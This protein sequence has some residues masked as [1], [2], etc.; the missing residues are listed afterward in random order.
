M[1]FPT[2][3]PLLDRIKAAIKAAAEAST[4]LD[5]ISLGDETG[6]PIQFEGVGAFDRGL[7]WLRDRKG[8]P[9]YMDF[10]LEQMLGDFAK[11][12]H[13]YMVVNTGLTLALP[14]VFKSFG[15]S[16]P[17]KDEANKRITVAIDPVYDTGFYYASGKIKG[18]AT[19]AFVQ[20]QSGNSLTIEF[21]IGNINAQTVMIHAVG[22]MTG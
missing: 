16:N 19:T 6:S 9:G 20:S 18:A 12:S 13:T 5:K 17:V 7:T 3:F 21:G 2:S 14:I 10:L 15:M 11:V 4:D 22:E 8:T 1:A